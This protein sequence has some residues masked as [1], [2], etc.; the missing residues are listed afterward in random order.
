MT[1][2]EIFK[3]LMAAIAGGAATFYVKAK[4][5]HRQMV[6]NEGKEIKTFVREIA[7]RSIRYFCTAYSSREEALQD[8]VV[9]AHDMRR[10]SND[11]DEF[12]LGK[13]NYFRVNFS[14]SLGRL[15]S[16]IMAPPFRERA[17]EVFG[18]ESPEIREIMDAECEVLKLIRQ[19]V[20]LS[21]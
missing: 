21:K 11:V 1:A 16:A 10:L 15:H 17:C 20:D 7:S 2:G 4:L 14:E 19:C 6:K 3:L 5:D 12:L 13:A 9:I 8:E 18:D